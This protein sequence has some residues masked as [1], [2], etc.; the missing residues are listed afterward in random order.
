MGKKSSKRLGYKHDRLFNFKLHFEGEILEGKKHG[1]GKEYDYK[2]RIIFE[3]EYFKGERWNGKVKEYDN[4]G[5]IINE[6]EYF[7]GKIIEDNNEK[8]NLNENKIVSFIK[9]FFEESDKLRFEG[10][11]LNDEKWNGIMYNKD[12]NFK[13][14]IKNGNWNLND[15]NF[16]IKYLGKGQYIIQNKNGRAYEYDNGYLLYEGKYLNDKRNGNGIEYDNDGKILFFGEYKNGER[17]NGKI[18]ELINNYWEEIEF[19][20]EYINGEKIGKGKYSFSAYSDEKYIYEGEFKNDEK[21]GYGKEYYKEYDTEKE[22]LIYEG[23]FKNDRRNGKGKEF[24]NGQLIFEGEYLNRKR[25]NGKYKLIDIWGKTLF[26]GELINGERKGKEYDNDGNLIYEGEYL[27][28]KKNGKG[29]EYFKNGKIKFEGEYILDIKWT[30]NIYDPDGNFIF[31][32]INGEGYGKE[33]DN[34]GN[35]IYDGEYLNG[36]KNGKGKEF[37]HNRLIFEGEYL[38]GK[39]NGNGKEYYDLKSIIKLKNDK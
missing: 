10:E 21:N 7:N 13:I 33:Y 36:V 18:K 22:I 32:M 2:N 25:W 5:G 9:E 24:N 34:D 17:W 29:K 8:L 30:G 26:E 4:N 6:K 35:L 3:G 1:K 38:N 27:N 11:Y 31:K 28:F 14:E 12:D 39:R 19:E 20:G 16:K 15:S 23:E 37:K